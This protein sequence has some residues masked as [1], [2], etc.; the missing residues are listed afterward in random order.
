VLGIGLVW[1][2]VSGLMI[3]L[4]IRVREK[5]LKAREENH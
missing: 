1:I 5:K 3:Y 4:R 2:V